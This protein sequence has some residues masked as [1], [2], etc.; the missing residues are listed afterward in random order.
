MSDQTKEFNAELDEVYPDQELAQF[1]MGYIND[2]NLWEE[3]F[4]HA[5]NEQGADERKLRKSTK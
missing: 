3:F 1:F 4:T 2:N 5:V